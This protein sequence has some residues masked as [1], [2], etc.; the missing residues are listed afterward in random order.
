MS[1]ADVV[2]SFWTFDYQINKN[3]RQNIIITT[4]ETRGKGGE[5]SENVGCSATNSRFIK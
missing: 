5:K 3:H 4:Y 1:A 2:C